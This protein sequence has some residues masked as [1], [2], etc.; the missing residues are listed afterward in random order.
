[1]TYIFSDYDG[2]IKTYEKNPSIIEQ[3][4]FNKN[5]KAINDFINRGNKFIITTG[6][7]YKSILA[8][9]KKYHINYNYITTYNGLVSYDD[10]GNLI[11]Q[12]NINKEILNEIR[13]LILNYKI[14][15]VL[16]DNYDITN[17]Y[18]NIIV[19]KIYTKDKYIYET[20]KKEIKKYTDLNITFDNLFK[21]ITLHVITNKSLGIKELI[22]DENVENPK[23]ITVGDSLNDI[24]M[25]KDYNGYKILISHPKLLFKNIKTTPS[26]HS[27]IKKQ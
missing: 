9:T 15:T 18:E 23:I 19:M 6:R 3:L 27:L 25:I 1:M 8:E 21:T 22:K 24:E 13:Q 11:Y 26:L 14:G 7:S 2:T 16:Y 17:I 10:K 5:I 12:K 20:L 4:T